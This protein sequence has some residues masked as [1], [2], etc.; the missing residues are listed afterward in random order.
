MSLPFFEHGT[1]RLTEIVQRGMLCA[2]DFDGTLAPIVNEP[3]RASIPTAILRRLDTLNQHVAVAIIT[4]RSVQDVVSR[5]NFRPEFVIGNHGIEGIPAWEDKAA[6]Y[7]ILCK[8]WEEMLT[9]AL[10]DHTAFEPGI[11]IEQKTYSLSVHYRQARDRAKVEEALQRLFASLMPTAHVVP[12]KCVFNLLPPNSPD[13]GMALTKL[14]EAF[15]LPTALFVGD[16]TTDEDVFK[17]HRPDWL[18]VRIERGHDSAA[19]FYLH[20]RLDMVELLDTLIH[21]LT[22]RQRPS[23]AASRR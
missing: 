5:L 3:S 15:A 22:G 10:R 6:S 11:W 9:D 19:E 4:G 8:N 21:H 7:R 17:L 18:T 16:D 13:K 2:F 20:H 23:I 1:Q 14:C 12:G